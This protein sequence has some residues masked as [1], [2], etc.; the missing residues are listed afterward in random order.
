[1]NGFTLPLASLSGPLA[2]RLSAMAA[3]AEDGAVNLGLA[4]LVL[5]AGWALARGLELG[6]RS[7]L[8][9]LRFNHR[10]RSLTGWVALD[11]GVEA[12]ALA[13]AALFWGTMVLA[14]LL[15]L[16]LV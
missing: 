9:A 10:L 5:L 15:A 12:S 3:G 2:D 7:T 4:L 16:D 6:F 13:G 1:M 11:N 8:R 14:M